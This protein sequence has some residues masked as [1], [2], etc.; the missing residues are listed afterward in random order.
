M[1]NLLYNARMALKDIIEINISTKGSDRVYLTL[2][3]DPPWEG[4]ASETAQQ[5][6]ER[7]HAGRVHTE[8]V[9]STIV[10][11]LQDMEMILDGGENAIGAL[12]KSEPVEIL[13]K[14]V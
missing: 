11:R 14:A 6:E 3:S 8:K 5:H 7:E 12:M 1:N 4:E 9:V 13:Q 10:D 2:L